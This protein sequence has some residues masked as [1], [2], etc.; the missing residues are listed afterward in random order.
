MV[1]RFEVDFGRVG[2][3]VELFLDVEGECVIR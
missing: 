2:R 3:D 1:F